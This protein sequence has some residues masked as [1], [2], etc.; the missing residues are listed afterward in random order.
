MHL[1]QNLP[2]Q[3]P[4]AMV[5]LLL[6]PLRVDTASNLTAKS[7]TALKSAVLCE[8]LEKRTIWKELVLFYF[9]ERRYRKER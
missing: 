4:A 5:H 6:L 1:L 7:C 8:I 2:R 9:G 3:L